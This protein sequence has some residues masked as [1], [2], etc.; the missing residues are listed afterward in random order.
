[1]RHAF[2]VLTASLGLAVGGLGAGAARAD[3][4]PDCALL[5][6]KA[7]SSDDLTFIGQCSNTMVFG[8]H[9]SEE[10]CAPYK[11]AMSKYCARVHAHMDLCDWARD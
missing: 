7:P 11:E 10:E 9:H 5:C 3:P 1:M 8:G 4:D 6:G 2:L